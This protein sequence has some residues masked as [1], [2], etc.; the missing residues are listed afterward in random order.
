MA[1][2]PISLHPPYIK[3]AVNK[4]RNIVVSIYNLEDTISALVTLFIWSS[5]YVVYN[6]WALDARNLRSPA[7]GT[8]G[9]QVF[10]SPGRS[11]TRKWIIADSFALSCN[12]E[13]S[14]DERVS[15]RLSLCVQSVLKTSHS[16]LHECRL[17]S[18]GDRVIIDYRK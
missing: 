6:H 15:A 13:R 3:P 11:R 7:A 12:S 16:G 10:A 4:S 8:C 17:L 1:L 9:T 5:S 14:A 2:I 18:Y